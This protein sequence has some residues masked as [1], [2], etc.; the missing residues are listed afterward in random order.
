MGRD[1]IKNAS[2]IGFGGGESGHTYGAI[3]G[4]GAGAATGV[5]CT[6]PSAEAKREA[7]Y[8]RHEEQRLRTVALEAALQLRSY[9]SFIEAYNDD[10][11]V[12]VAKAFYDFLTSS[13]SK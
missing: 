13:E 5:N 12:E 4:S 2:N 6:N 8:K 11:V 9:A 1:G 10:R 3:I 7:D